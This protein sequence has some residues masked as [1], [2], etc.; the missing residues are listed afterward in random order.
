MLLFISERLNH[1][2]RAYQKKTWI[3]C[4]LN[5]QI[6]TNS[7]WDRVPEI[8]RVPALTQLSLQ[9]RAQVSHRHLVLSAGPT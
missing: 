7:A 4:S 2:N 9:R 6:L 3:V 5:S 1:L 8:R